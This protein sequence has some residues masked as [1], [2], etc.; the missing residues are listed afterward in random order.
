[1]AVRVVKSVLDRY[2]IT[3]PQKSR[4]LYNTDVIEPTPTSTVGSIGSKLN[5][6]SFQISAA[7]IVKQKGGG[8]DE[9]YFNCVL[10]IHQNNGFV[11]S[12]SFRRGTIHRLVVV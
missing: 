8:T 9:V 5:E 3:S 7:V 11:S 1:M 10:D 12:F 2:I 4:L 6:N